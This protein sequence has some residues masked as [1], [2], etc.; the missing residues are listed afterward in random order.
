M[1][2]QINTELKT[3]KLEESTNLGNFYE[4][5]KQMLPDWKE[6]KL[7]TNTT[8]KWNTYPIYTNPYPYQPF[9][10]YPWITCTGTTSDYKSN[11]FN[12]DLKYK[13]C[14]NEIK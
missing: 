7:E 11:I 1:K 13:N 8:I 9:R 12:V 14:V 10:T 4:A 3:I 6:Y 5:I 2:I